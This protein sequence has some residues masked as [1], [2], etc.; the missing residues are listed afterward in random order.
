MTTRK[1]KS[2]KRARPT[3]KAVVRWMLCTFVFCALIVLAWRVINPGPYCAASWRPWTCWLVTC[4]ASDIFSLRTRSPNL[5]IS[6][7]KPEKQS[8]E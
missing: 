5:Q 6:G 3:I 7:P 2:A 8:H 1:T 4:L